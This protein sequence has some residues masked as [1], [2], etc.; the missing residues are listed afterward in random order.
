MRWA[1]TLSAGL[2]LTAAI[3]VWPAPSATPIQGRW[4]AGVYHLG[5]R[6]PLQVLVPVQS[7]AFFLDGDFVEGADWGDARIARLVQR[8][9]SAFPGSLALEAEVQVFATGEVTLPRLRLSV[10]TADK[11]QAYSIAVAPL[12]IAPL[13]PPGNPPRPAPAAPLALPAPFPWPWLVLG[14]GL[15]AAA[16]LVLLRW[17]RHGNERPA[18]ALP[19]PGL[20]ETDPDRWVR[21][22][23]ERLFRGAVPAPLRYGALTVLLR[24]YIEIKSGLP[25]LEW[26]TTEV[27]RGCHRLPALSG[28]PTTD[29]MGVLALCDGV[30]FARYIPEA[31]EEDEAKERAGRLIAAL[32]QPSPAEK[33]S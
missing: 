18:A 19:P 1:R 9:P 2:L 29:L 5:D 21:E 13:L 14:L 10:H 33:A 23:C 15:A 26:T 27:H 30:L 28:A 4:T 31:A 17:L 6:V 12:A 8:P 3:A 25:F 22:E 32:A 16:L 24:D 11:V 20:R 7:D